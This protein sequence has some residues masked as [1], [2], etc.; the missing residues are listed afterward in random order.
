V[1]QQFLITT[2]ILLLQNKKI[3]KIL[4]VTVGIFP[5]FGTGTSVKSGGVK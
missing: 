2:V 5:W 3:K 4:H 1:Y